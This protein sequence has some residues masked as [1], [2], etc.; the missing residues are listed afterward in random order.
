M[1]STDRVAKRSKLTP[2]GMLLTI[3]AV[4]AIL[5]KGVLYRPGDGGPLLV[6][7]ALLDMTSIILLPA[8]VSL[9]IIG[10][11]RDRRANNAPASR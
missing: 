9:W 2:A 7:A 5:G 1:A 6:L 8:G 11:L 10:A 3:L 4:G